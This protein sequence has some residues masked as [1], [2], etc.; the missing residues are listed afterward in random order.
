MS[1]TARPNSRDPATRIA[2]PYHSARPYFSAI[3]SKAHSSCPTIT[4][5]LGVRGTLG[6][7]RQAA[8][9]SR[10]REPPRVFLEP[11]RSMS[12]CLPLDHPFIARWPG[13]PRASARA[14]P[15]AFWR[16][17]SGA[18]RGGPATAAADDFP[19]ALRAFPSRN[20]IAGL[21]HPPLPLRPS[22]L[23]RVQV[24]PARRLRRHEG[25]D[26]RGRSDEESRDVH[27]S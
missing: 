11:G 23:L 24:R 27:R 9:G 5:H 12:A 13:F 18:R 20:K 4:A 8:E 25:R 22:A 15:T 1:A 10:G 6:S 19:A 14:A 26:G 2:P 16:G 3:R 7:G 21:R 17:R